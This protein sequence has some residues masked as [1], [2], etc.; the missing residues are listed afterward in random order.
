LVSGKKTVSLAEAQRAQRFLL[1]EDSASLR[2][3]SSGS[4][5][6]DLDF[7]SGI[8]YD[9]VI[10]DGLRSYAQHTA[11]Y[12]VYFTPPALLVGRKALSR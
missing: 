4:G 12:Y 3:R 2:E 10:M 6:I 5:K 9:A 11:W 7:D 8:G 1:F